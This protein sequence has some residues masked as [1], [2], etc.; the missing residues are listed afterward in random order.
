MTQ[1]PLDWRGK[2]VEP[3]ITTV[4]GSAPVLPSNPKRRYAIFINNS[5][6]LMYL[7]KNEVGVVNAGIRLNANGGSYEIN[8]TNP[9]FGPISVAS[10]NAGDLLLV[11]EEE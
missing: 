5:G 9:Y 7:H 11:T 1:Q 2:V 3:V 10:G 6:N 4:V 8:F